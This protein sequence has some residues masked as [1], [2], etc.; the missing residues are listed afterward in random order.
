MKESGVRRQ[1]RGMVEDIRFGAMAASMKDT[2]RM[3]KQTEGAG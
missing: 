2:G 3:T 1:T